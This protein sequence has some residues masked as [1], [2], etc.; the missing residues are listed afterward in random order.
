MTKVHFRVYKAHIDVNLKSIKQ[1]SCENLFSHCKHNPSI[2]LAFQGILL[3]LQKQRLV[4]NTV[5]WYTKKTETKVLNWVWGETFFS[6]FKQS[7]VILWTK[8]KT[9]TTKGSID[10]CI[11]NTY[12]H[13][14]IIHFPIKSAG[15]VT[16]YIILM[17][18]LI[19]LPSKIIMAY[20]IC[21]NK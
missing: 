10:L 3:F 9:T 19:F 14:Y 13:I 12:T 20:L 2:L 21:I 5:H 18:F 7:I 4:L 8:R 15:R 17:W 1:T 16:V 11:Y 6:L